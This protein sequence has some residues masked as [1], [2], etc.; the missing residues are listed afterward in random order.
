MVSNEEIFDALNKIDTYL[1][2]YKDKYVGSPT[3]NDKLNLGI[4]AQELQKN[5]LT[6]SCVVEGPEGLLEID[7]RFLAMT[8]MSL[9]PVFSDEIT[10]INERITKIEEGR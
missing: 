6:R 4:L 2:R 7:S 9:L 8:I 10:K 1:Y 3:T 5:P